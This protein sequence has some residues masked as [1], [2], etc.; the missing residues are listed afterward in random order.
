M[1]LSNAP[2]HDVPRNSPPRFQ[3]SLGWLMIAMSVVCVTLGVWVVLPRG[4][5]GYLILD[6]LILGAVP[7]VLVTCT[8]YARGDTQAFAIGALVPW[9]SLILTRNGPIP[10]WGLGFWSVFVGGLCGALAVA[11]RRWLQDRSDA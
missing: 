9:L 5:I 7:T 6:P 8:I 11:L 10:V 1:A 3:F 4:I 2:Q